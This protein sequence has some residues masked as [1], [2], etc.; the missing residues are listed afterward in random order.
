MSIF[1]L[2]AIYPFPMEVMGCHTPC[3]LSCWKCLPALPSSPRSF[4]LALKHY[5]FQPCRSVFCDKV[6][7]WAALLTW[8]CCRKNSLVT[9]FH[10]KTSDAWLSSEIVLEILMVLSLMFWLILLVNVN[11]VFNSKLNNNEV[12]DYCRKLIF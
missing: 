4:C 10:L 11:L 3:L 6:Q 9:V 1:S 7:L 5:L 2:L 12:S 8:V